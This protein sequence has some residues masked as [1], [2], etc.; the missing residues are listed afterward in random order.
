MKANKLLLSTLALSLISLQSMAPSDFM[1]KTNSAR[2]RMPASDS[3]AQCGIKKVPTKKIVAKKIV[4]SKEMKALQE[5]LAKL[6]SD[7]KNKEDLL[8][9]K[10]QEIEQL[11]DKK[12]DEKIEN[13]NQLVLDQKSDIENLRLEIKN[14][15]VKASEVKE[16]KPKQEKNVNDTSVCKAELKGEKL[17][18][19]VKKQL[20]DKEA[21]L[22]ELEGLKKENEELKT[23]V[24]TKS[25][26]KKSD[27]QKL[28]AKNQN[29]DLIALMSQMTSMF[30]AQMQAQMQL[31]I[32]TMNMLSQMQTNF[33]PQMNPYS[34]T[35]TLGS[36]DLGLG[37]GIGIPA[38]NTPWT[39]DFQNPYSASLPQLIRQ[40]AQAPVFN[41]FNFGQD[42]VIPAPAKVELPKLVR[43]YEA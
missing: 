3:N 24:A 26:E 5:K 36:Q 27:E 13:L 29:A 6:E 38:F 20:E 10:S 34:M 43:T 14:S 31:Q 30:S 1:A 15:Q 19:D 22:K 35:N 2:G 28:D 42:Q 23:K 33:M 39:N 41:G 32:Q 40:P 9:K 7:L 16:E 8:D 4:T 18:A 12:Y 25:P 11:K 21:V 17:E 37:Y